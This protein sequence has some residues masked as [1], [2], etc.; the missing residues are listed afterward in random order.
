MSLLR[1][2]YRALLYLCPPAFRRRFGW[3]MAGD[4]EEI[5]REVGRPSDLRDWVPVVRAMGDVVRTALR[6]WFRRATRRW[7]Q[8][9]VSMPSTGPG[10][11]S[12]GRMRGIGDA[13]RRDLQYAVRQLWRERTL[14]SVIVLTLAVG[15]GTTAAIFSVLDTVVLRPLPFHDPQAVY[16]IFEISPQGSDYTTS[17]PMLLDWQAM[18]RSF[19]EVGA[20]TFSSA[21]VRAGGEPA[22]VDGGRVTQNLM[23]LLGLRPVLGRGFRPEEDRPNPSQHVVILGEGYWRRRFGGDPAVVGATISMSGVPTVVV[24]VADLRQIRLLDYVEQLDYLVPLAADPT[25]S[26]RMHYLT[27]LGRLAPDVSPAR[28]R[29][30]LNGIARR[31]ARAHPESNQGWGAGVMPAQEWIVT[32]RVRTAIAALAGAVVVLLLLTCANVSSLL[33]AKATTRLEEL[34]VRSALGASRPRIIGQ[35]MTESLLFACLGG[36]AGLAVAVGLI[37]AVR[38]YGP[39]DVP[40][41]ADVALDGPVLLFTLGAALATCLMFGAVPAWH[42]SRSGASLTV[43]RVRGSSSSGTWVRD[44]LIVGELALAMIILVGVGLTGHSFHRLLRV[45]PGFE[46]AGLYAVRLSR[47]PADSVVDPVALFSDLERRAAGVPGIAGAGLTYIE[48]FGSNNTS[49]RVAPEEWHATT[50]EEFLG[51]DWRAVTPGFFTILGVQPR[52]GRLLGDEDAKAGSDTLGATPVVIDEALAARLWEGEDPVGHTLVWSRPGGTRL[53][54]V[55]VV[56]DVKDVHMDRP[57]RGTVYFHHA[58][59]PWSTMTLLLRVRGN[60]QQVLAAV[61]HQ[62]RAAAPGIPIPTIHSIGE[63]MRRSVAMPRFILQLFGLFGT[64]AILLAMTGVYGVLA[65]HVTRRTREIAVRVA[66]GAQT[67]DVLHLILS[68]VAWRMLAGLLLGLGGALVAARW[69]GA[70]LY[71]IEP[72]DPLAYLAAAAV[73]AM[74]A[75]AATAPPARRAATVDPA[76]ALTAE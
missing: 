32:D 5:C 54:V 33:V 27:A 40:R 47:P 43:N 58:A 57:G 7:P 67:R 17:E 49:H 4:F 60:P 44:A 39:A 26:R 63:N 22:S 70:V 72:T 37:G 64:V 56:E 19:G 3:Q 61:R 51:V 50:Q 59:Q 12:Q 29:A 66:V 34:G 46:T 52:K 38:A 25:A 9:V 30:E 21:I 45:D 76:R 73:L 48:P 35:L 28:A 15:L 65:H 55:G 41:L 62:I 18:V 13:V 10:G 75:L 8:A 36:G 16:R 11:A 74:A 6:E 20:Y 71:D 68:Q 14:T 2:L 24:G 31:M 53:S 42:G 23:P 1:L 69:I